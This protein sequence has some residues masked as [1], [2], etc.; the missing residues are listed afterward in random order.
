[1]RGSAQQILRFD[2]FRFTSHA[3]ANEHSYSLPVPDLQKRFTIVGARA[4][5]AEPL[6]LRGSLKPHLLLFSWMRNRMGE[7]CDLGKNLVCVRDR[8]GRYSC[9][10]LC[11]ECEREW[12][13]AS[14]A[15]A[16]SRGPGG[17]NI[18]G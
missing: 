6:K 3:V 13:R 5:P 18:H 10:D 16:H 9:C 7:I 17:E 2:R 14:R 12:R 4:V 15:A 8:A 11:C 1:V